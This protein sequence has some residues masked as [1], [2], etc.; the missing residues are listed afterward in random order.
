VRREYHAT[1][2][3]VATH[4]D[5]GLF[6]AVISTEAVD[7]END[8]VVASAMV[9]ALRAWTETGKVIPL[10]WNHSSDPE[11]IVGH[12]KPDSVEEVDGEVV[13]S[14][15]VDQDV[16]RGRQ[17]WRLMK[18]GTLGFSFGYKIDDSI[19]RADGVREIRKLDVFEVSATPTPLNQGTR[20]L[21]TKSTA[22]RVPTD[23]ELRAEARRLGIEMPL[24][25]RQLRRRCDEI[26][27]EVALGGE[28]PPKPEPPKQ[29]EELALRD[30]RRR[31]DKSRLEVA[32]GHPVDWSAGS[33]SYTTTEDR[34]FKRV[35]QEMRDFMFKTLT[36]GWSEGRR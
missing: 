29:D 28:R 17:T 14:G 24:S 34:E 35:R 21:S 6:T 23:A 2:K 4:T 31:C 13:A 27:L 18:S 1:F 9:K 33:A 10:A 7:R 26:A 19:R 30:L 22:I 16:E 5:Q 36:E 15:W 25:N 11:D 20:V 3:A 32:L 8:V 12:I